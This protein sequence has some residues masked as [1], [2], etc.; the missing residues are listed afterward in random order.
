MTKGK[1]KKKGVAPQL[2]II[3]DG[4]SACGESVNG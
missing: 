3:H 4:E 1:G 2:A